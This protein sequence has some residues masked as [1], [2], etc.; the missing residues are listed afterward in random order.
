[1]HKIEFWSRP[2]NIEPV[3]YFQDAKRQFSSRE[4]HRFLRYIMPSRQ[5]LSMLCSCQLLCSSRSWIGD[6]H[7]RINP[8]FL[9]IMLIHSGRTLVRHNRDYFMAEP[10]DVVLL[11]PNADYEFM[12]DGFCERSAVVL[13]GAGVAGLLTASGLTGKLCVSMT[14]TSAVEKCFDRMAVA[15]PESHLP[16]ARHNISVI[17][18]ELIQLLAKPETS[19]GIPAELEMVLSRI[20]HE[21][22]SI[23][24]LEMLA[25]HAGT[26]V[27]NL[28]RLFRQH[29]H[30]TPHRY[31]IDFRMRHAERLLDEHI[32]SIKEI[33]QLVGYANP[34]NFSTEFHRRH[35]C[36]PREWSARNNA[37]G[38]DRKS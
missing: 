34:L 30:T 12:S 21:Y 36:S 29:L 31:L 15:L 10:G 24:T 17:G 26:S 18:F 7:R 5:D 19:A 22:A 28:I 4:R 35:G 16:H 11:H 2:D 20:S 14:D 32:C 3:I 27:T 37:S 1:M 23:L 9:T 25:K 6:Y 38:S 33:A 13:E 8:D